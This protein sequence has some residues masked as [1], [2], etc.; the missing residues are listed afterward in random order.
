MPRIVGLDLSLTG[1][2]IA[3]ISWDHATG[4]EVTV[5]KVGTKAPARRKGD[6]PPSLPQRSARLRSLAGQV[7]QR[8]VGAS[9]VIVEGPAYSKSDS[10]TWD[11]AGLWWLVVGRLTGGGLTVVEADPTTIKTYALGKGSGAGTRS[12]SGTSSP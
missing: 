3:T 10:G 4:Q 7:A 2:G 8:C 11:R 5:E 9:L 12:S 1:T 6:P